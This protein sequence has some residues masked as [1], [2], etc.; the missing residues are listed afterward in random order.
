[1]TRRN[2]VILSLFVAALALQLGILLAFQ[3]SRQSALDQ[4][5][6][7]VVRAEPVDPRDLFRGDYVI[8]RYGFSRI[9]RGQVKDALGE[10]DLRGAKVYVKIKQA[11]PD[12]GWTAVDVRRRPFERLAPDEAMLAGNITDHSPETLNVAYGCE[13][14]FVPEGQGKPIEKNLREHKVTVEL[15]V[16]RRG[17]AQ[18][19]KLF[20]DGQPVEFK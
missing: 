7:L 5:R 16:T 19:A 17:V 15:S 3:F 11:A 8:L 6:R 18:P 1:M 12:A 4:G 9:D 20:I 13:D 14:V 10:T 2:A